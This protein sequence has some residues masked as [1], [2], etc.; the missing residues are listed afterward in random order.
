M[1]D[2]RRIVSLCWKS[3]GLHLHN[4]AALSLDQPTIQVL[5]KRRLSSEF[6]PVNCLLTLKPRT[7]LKEA[8]SVCASSFGDAEFGGIY[9]SRQNSSRG[10]HLPR[11]RLIGACPLGV[12]L[13]RLLCPYLPQNILL[14][15]MASTGA[16][17]GSCLKS[18]RQR[19]LEDERNDAKKLKSS[20]E[21]HS[22]TGIKSAEQV[23]TEVQCNTSEN[24][25]NSNEA[26]K[27]KTKRERLICHRHWE[28]TKKGKLFYSSYDDL[29]HAV[30]D[31]SIASYNV[32]AQNLLVENN[33]LYRNCDGKYL[34]WNIRKELL[35]SE[36]KRLNPD[37]LCLQEVNE[38]H[39]GDFFLPQL[40]RLGYSGFYKKR[41]GQRKDGCATF[42]KR[43]KF[44]C[45]LIYPVEYLMPEV[46]LLD[47]DNVAL[48][49]LLQPKRCDRAID[50][51][52]CIAN[53]HLL[54]N[55]RR[56][57]IKLAQLMR[58]FA[59]IDKLV[60]KESSSPLDLTY[61]PVVICGDFNLEPFSNL[62]DFVR[63]GSLM[64]DGRVIR[65][66][67]GQ[68]SENSRGSDRC[69]DAGFLGTAAGITD[70]CQF[71]DVAVG[72]MDKARE[73]VSDDG[74]LSGVDGPSA[75]PP[76]PQPLSQGS[77]RI[78]HRLGLRSVYEHL[79]HSLETGEDEFEATT[80]HSNACCTVD[81]IFYSSAEKREKKRSKNGVI[82]SG[83]SH[84]ELISRLQL[85]STREMEIVGELP[86]EFNASDHTIL[87]AKFSFKL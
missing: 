34:Q 38:E 54:F 69:L 23:A 5:R 40:H 4:A 36:L 20:E 53:T 81:Y 86:N 17:S 18:G 6:I 78:T 21:F 72:R 1:L 24:T 74:S 3:A 57:D 25:E 71:L 66:L 64:C 77:G 80:Y 39:F 26:R 83:G 32:L 62:Y 58:L 33:Y 79:R 8:G 82:H 48:V 68:E 65:K 31:F 76:P 30:Y 43:E 44:D 28:I 2:N 85:L 49:L 11:A 56:G 52:V 75:A 70:Q 14:A 19:S 63:R 67:S 9:P 16:D 60:Y 50:A 47:R 37:I 13:R 10:W 42:F 45:Q 7:T 35:L 73:T 59:E 61:H 55:P 84:L 46:P 22:V 51:A 15:Q 27:A 29:S 87:M 41:T 12:G